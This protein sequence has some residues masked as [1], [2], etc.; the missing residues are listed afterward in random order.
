MTDKVFKEFKYSIIFNETSNKA[1]VYKCKECC[2]QSTE[3]NL[4]A[5]KHDSSPGCLISDISIW[6]NYNR[7][8]ASISMVCEKILVY[9]TLSSMF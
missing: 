8:P 5:H 9:T 2:K 4:I 1:Q 6:K 7:P 3:A